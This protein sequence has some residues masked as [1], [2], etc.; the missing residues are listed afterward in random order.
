MGAAS[1]LTLASP[2]LAV[3]IYVNTAPY[4]GN[5][6][7][8]FFASID[9]VTGVA[10]G[11]YSRLGVSSGTF[12]DRF[13]FRLNQIGEG[14]GSITSTISGDITN[15]LNTTNL[16]FISV[17]LWNQFNWFTIPISTDLNGTEHGGAVNI[18]IF[19]ALNPNS[20]NILEVTYLSRGA[21]SF[22][23]DLNF[24]PVPEPA[25]WMLLMAGFGALGFALRR[26]KQ[27]NVR[28]RFAF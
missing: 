25:A 19:A 24:T 22:G 10:S 15:P 16:D 20:Y 12:T 6:V 9:P 8:T 5:G 23:G 1:A 21:G 14:S 28:V 7:G 4:I 26:K 27:E 18:P 13:L 3:D 17:R 2:A 11:A